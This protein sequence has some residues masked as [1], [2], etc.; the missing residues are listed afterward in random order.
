MLLLSLLVIPLI[1]IFI[2]STILSSD[3]SDLNLKRIKYTALFTSILTLFVSL[4]IYI[5]YDF[6]NKQFQF[7][8]EYHKVNFLD[9]YLGIDGLSI[10]FVMLTT[11]I[12]PIAL[13]SN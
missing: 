1:G 12:M 7:V 5:L 11:I 6:S 13:L 3:L 9:I 8:Q 2:I 4:I 10:Y